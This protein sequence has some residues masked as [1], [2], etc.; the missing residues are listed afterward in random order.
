MVLQPFLG[1]WPLFQSTA[2]TFSA[3]NESNFADINN[4]QGYWPLAY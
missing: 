3:R 1:P 2:V 4:T